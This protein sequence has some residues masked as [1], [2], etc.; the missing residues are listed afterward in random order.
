MLG[1]YVTAVEPMR[2]F[3]ARLS[4]AERRPGVLSVSLAHS[5]PWG[6]SVDMG[7]RVVVVA[8][9]DDD[10]AHTIAEE[11]A[12]DFFA[13]RREVTLAPLSMED[14]LDTAFSRPSADAPV[15]VAD[16]ADNAGGGA[17]S[18]STFVLRELL[19]RDAEN[20][21]IAAIW[22]PVVVRL[23]FAA[24]VGASL[25]V[26]L[27]GKLGPTSGDPLDLTVTVEGLVRELIQRWPQT[28][29]RHVDVPYGDSAWLRAGGVDVIV[30]S[31]RTQVKGLEPFTAFGIDP[32]AK[33]VLVVKSTNHFRAAFE[34]IASEVIYMS[35]PGALTFDFPSIPYR[36][37]DT[38]KYP[39]I[40]DPW[41]T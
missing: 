38:N 9:G 23:A 36:R 8:D 18:D 19:E 10:L 22:D 3:V 16:I 17:P 12:R 35:A 29:G 6:D 34:P 5:F 13:M 2:S 1:I 31:I 26:R 28:R 14:A 33:H 11:L 7:A 25:T 41:A 32:T 24:G 4:E 30:N 20:A 40:D 27:G 15:V 21:A 37:L 39:W